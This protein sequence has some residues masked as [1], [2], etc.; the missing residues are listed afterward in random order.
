LHWL[1][2]EAKVDADKDRPERWTADVGL[3]ELVVAVARAETRFR[4]PSLVFREDEWILG[5]HIQPRATRV[6]AAREPI[7]QHVPERDVANTHERTI[8]IVARAR[9]RAEAV[10]ARPRVRAAL[11]LRRPVIRFN[12]V[13]PARQSVICGG[14]ADL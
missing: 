4:I 3:R 7:V 12:V 6:D 2:S 14:E 8:H 1:G 13:K 5:A 10:G 11:I 9:V